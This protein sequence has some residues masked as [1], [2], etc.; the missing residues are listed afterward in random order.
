MAM[1]FREVS[2]RDVLFTLLGAVAKQALCGASTVE[3]HVS[4]DVGPVALGET[5]KEKPVARFASRHDRPKAATLSLTISGKPLLEQSS[6]KIGIDQP[7]RHRMDRT[8][9]IAIHE[10]LLLHPTPEP[11][12]HVH[13]HIDLRASLR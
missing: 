10:P 11:T 12:H 3:L 5:V 4:T 1:D 8:T 2:V 13:R 7:S 9:D 6:T